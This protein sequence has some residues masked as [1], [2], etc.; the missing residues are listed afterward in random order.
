MKG[1]TC[2]MRKGARSRAVFCPKT[3]EPEEQKEPLDKACQTPEPGSFPVLPAFTG[4]QVGPFR[5]EGSPRGPPDRICSRCGY[6]WFAIC[7]SVQGQPPF[8]PPCCLCGCNLA[9]LAMCQHGLCPQVNPLGPFTLP[10]LLGEWCACHSLALAEQLFWGTAVSLSQ[11][12]L[13]LV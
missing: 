10:C 11:S 2:Q 5:P 9:L 1:P 13:A 7:P 12:A 8:A 4:G 3:T 6:G